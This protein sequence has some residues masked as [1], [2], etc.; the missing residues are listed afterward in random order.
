MTYSCIDKHNPESNITLIEHNQVEHPN[1]PLCTTSSN[2]CS[3]L[4]IEKQKTFQLSG[5]MCFV[6]KNAFLTEFFFPNEFVDCFKF[7]TLHTKVN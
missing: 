3:L 6:Y 2:M 7:S 5:L 4:K 1:V